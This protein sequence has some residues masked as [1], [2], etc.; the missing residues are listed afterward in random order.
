MTNKRTHKISRIPE[1]WW[2]YKFPFRPLED[3]GWMMKLEDKEDIK[4]TP[5]YNKLFFTLLRDFTKAGWEGVGQI[6]V[7]FHPD[8]LNNGPQLVLFHVQ[9][10]K[11]DLS[12]IASPIELENKPGLE[13]VK[14]GS[15][16]FCFYDE[17]GNHNP[18]SL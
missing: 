8:F 10:D 13:L 3:L 7:I 11:D 4:G 16:D 9:H 6:H 18:N 15:Y 1:D 14:K 5:F 12:W 2:I 17:D